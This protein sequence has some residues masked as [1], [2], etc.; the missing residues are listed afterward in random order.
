M[1]KKSDTAVVPPENE[2]KK[3][4]KRKEK[5]TRINIASV[6]AFDIPTHSACIHTLYSSTTTAPSSTSVFDAYSRYVVAVFVGTL[7]TTA[8]TVVKQT[9]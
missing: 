8:V 5:E 4:K 7:V 9:E 1:P 2:R 6:L 3:E